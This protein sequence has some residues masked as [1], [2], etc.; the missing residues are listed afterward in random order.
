VPSFENNPKIKNSIISIINA[1][2]KLKEFG[3][4]GVDSWVEEIIKALPSQAN[5]LIS[6]KL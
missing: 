2:E 5:S 1:Q 6:I 3:L 4:R